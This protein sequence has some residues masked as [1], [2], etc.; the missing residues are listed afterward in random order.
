MER[1][2]HAV[3]SRADMLVW[4]KLIP[5]QLE[6]VWGNI[7]DQE[8]V[9]YITG[10]NLTLRRILLLLMGGPL[11]TLVAQSQKKSHKYDE[12]TGSMD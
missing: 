9:I 8:V 7:S 2:S 10:G 5:F 4:I 12:N 11:R 3:T 6:N 1:Q